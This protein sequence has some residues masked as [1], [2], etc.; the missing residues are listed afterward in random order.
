MIFSE[1]PELL[2][3]MPI[4]KATGRTSGGSSNAGAIAGGIVAGALVISITAAIIIFYLRR[5]HPTASS[6]STSQAPLEVQ[7]PLTPEVTFPSNSALRP[8]PPVTPMRL[9]VRGFRAFAVVACVLMFGSLFLGT[10]RIRTFRPHS[11]SLR[12]WRVSPLPSHRTY[13]T[14]T[15]LQT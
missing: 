15:K 2:P 5:R 12:Q 1:S 7:Q 3:G 8:E 6:A 11:Q 10:R 13:R 9:Y 14:L 4:A